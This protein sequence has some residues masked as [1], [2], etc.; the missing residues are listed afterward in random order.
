MTLDQFMLKQP[1]LEWCGRARMCRCGCVPDNRPGQMVYM[2]KTEEYA[3]SAIQYLC[4]SPLSMGIYIFHHTTK[5][6]LVDN[7]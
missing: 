2:F 5:G 7:V 1:G 4:D 3:H 6:I